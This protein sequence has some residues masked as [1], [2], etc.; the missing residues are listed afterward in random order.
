MG[1][2]VVDGMVYVSQKHELTELRD[3]NGDEVARRSAHRGHLA[4]RRQLPRVRVR[5]ALQGRELLPQPVG[6]RSTWAARPPTR[7]RSAAAARASW[8]TGAPARS[9]RSRAACAPRTGSAG[10]PTATS[11]SPTTRAAGCPS[12]KLVQDREGRVLQPLTNPDGPF[13]DQ[14]VT[15][16]VLWLPQNEIA[17]SPSTPVLLKTGPYA[18]QMLIGDVT[19][20]GLQRGYLETVDGEDQGA[21]FRHTQ[22]L[23]A[24]VNRGVDRPG[25][26]DLRRRPR[27]RRQL[28]P[29]GQAPLRPAEAH[30]ERHRRLRHDGHARHRDR[31]R[32]RVHRAA[33]R[34]DRR[35]AAH[36]VPRRAVALRADRAVRRPRRWTRRRCR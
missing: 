32:D 26:R 27:R 22:G 15:Q 12:S 14:P 20:G 31:L 30:P 5:P 36:R 4:V 16:P 33:L 13:D 6:R 17:N 8:S 10:G 23:E 9:P 28:G 24:G 19:Y 25:R 21:V 18:G 2:A 1:I 11:T 34:R 29:G 3:T 7:S 35:E